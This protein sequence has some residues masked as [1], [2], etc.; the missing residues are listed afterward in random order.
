MIEIVEGKGVG[1][2]KSYYVACRII[3]QLSKG[4]TV[5]ASDTF[6]LKWDAVKALVVERYGVELQEGQYRV[7]AEDDVPRLHEVTPQGTEECAVLVV[8]DEC[9]S[10]LNARDWNDSSKR[11]FFNWLTQSRHDDTD[12]MFISQ[13]SANI[14]KQIARLVTY[15]RRI[16]N[17]A[18]W[19][20]PGIGNWPLKQFVINT[21]DSDGKTSLE[22]KY[23]WHDKGIFACYTSKVMKGRH[24]RTGEVVTKRVLAKVNRR[25]TMF[26]P[27]F[28]LIPLLLIY[29]ASKLYGV[30]SSDDESKQRPVAVAAAVVGPGVSGV[31]TMPVSTVAVASRFVREEWRSCSGGDQGLESRD[32]MRVGHKKPWTLVTALGCYTEGEASQHGFVRS[33]RWPDR[34]RSFAIAR[35]ENAGALVYVVA[36]FGNKTVSVGVSER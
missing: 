8:V 22:K 16:R 32:G 20:I 6:G 18:N 21:L 28:L 14:D 3:E 26:R 35:C 4:G 7:F 5:C 27:L 19:K 34:G 13:H 11:P 15:V 33:I 24:R 1:A 31:A 30:L 17:M 12:V 36:E 29:G 10:K 2:G 23:V 9:H 25:T